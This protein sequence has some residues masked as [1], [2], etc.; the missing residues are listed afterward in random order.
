MYHAKDPNGILTD[1]HCTAY[2]DYHAGVP[3]QILHGASAPDCSTGEYTVH[4]VVNDL[5]LVAQ[6]AV[7]SSPAIEYDY[8]GLGR[9]KEVRVPGDLPIQVTYPTTNGF[10]SQRRVQQ[11][12]FWR[13]ESYDGFGLKTETRSSAGELVERHYDALG[14]KVFASLA[15]FTA[16]DLQGEQFSYDPLGRLRTVTHPGGS[17]LAYAYG[18]TANTLTITDE[19]HRD[20]VQTFRAFAAPEP[21]RLV[22]VQLP[23]EAAPA[24]DTY[25]YTVGGLLTGIQYAGR[26]RSLDY[27]FAKSVVRQSSPESGSVYFGYDP[28]GNLR[29]RDRRSS[30]TCSDANFDDARADARFI[31]DGAGRVRQVLHAS[32]AVPDVTFTFDD[33]NN[34]ASMSDGVGTHV[35]TYTGAGRLQSDMSTVAGVAYSIGYGY[36]AHG[37]LAT[38]T[39]P[40]GRQLTY[41]RDAGN[42]VT[43]IREGAYAYLGGVGYHA[44]GQASTFTYGNGL[45]TTQTQDPRQ[46]PSRLRAAGVFDVRYG[47]DDAGNVTGL[48]DGIEP[49]NTS[50]FG[51]DEKDRLTSASG[52]WG[53]TTYTYNTAG[54]RLTETVDGQTTTYGYDSAGRLASLGG[55]KSTTFVHDAFGNVVQRLDPFQNRYVYD[56]DSDGHLADVKRA[57]GADPAQ[58]LAIFH[59]DGQ[60]RRAIEER[61]GTGCGNRVLHYDRDGNRIAESSESGWILKEMVVHGGQTLAEIDTRPLRSTPAAIDFGSVEPNQ[62]GQQTALLANR[63]AQALTLSAANLPQGFVLG[64]TLP[65]SIPAGG[66]RS[67]AVQFKPASAGVFGGDLTA[68]LAGF[69]LRVPLAGVGGGAR[70]SLDA[71]VQD[72]GTVWYGAPLTRPFRVTNTGTGPLTIQGWDLGGREDLFSVEPAG[73]LT[74]QPGELQDFTLTLKPRKSCGGRIHATVALL[75]NSLNLPN[76]DRFDISATVR[77]LMI[78]QTQFDFA[79]VAAGASSTID[80]PVVNVS[81]ELM[82]LDFTLSGAPQFELAGL[83]TADLAPGDTV[84]VPIT[85]RPTAA[86]WSPF[87][88]HAALRIRFPGCTAACGDDD[89]PLDVH[90]TGM[91]PQEVIVEGPTAAILQAQFLQLV[92]G[93][94]Q[95]L[96]ATK[97]SDPI[98]GG[99][100]L[101]Y[102]TR[103]PQGTWS[104]P[105]APTTA[106]VNGRLA[107][108]VAPDGRA[109]LRTNRPG[110]GLTQFLMQRAPGGAFGAEC[111]VAG[112]WGT[113]PLVYD[114]AGN[115]WVL[116]KTG[117]TPGTY[118]V[119]F[120]P[121]FSP[122]GT[123][124]AGQTPPISFT[125]DVYWSVRGG[126]CQGAGRPVAPGRVERHQDLPRDLRSGAVHDADRVLRAVRPPGRLPGAGRRPAGHLSSCLL[127]E[128]GRPLERSVVTAVSARGAAVPDAPLGRRVEPA[129]TSC[130]N[131]QVM[132]R[133]TCIRG[134]S[135]T[136]RA[137]CTSVP[138]TVTRGGPVRRATRIPSGARTR[139]G[140]RPRSCQACRRYPGS[141][142][143][144]ARATE[145]PRPG[146]PSRRLVGRARSSATARCWLPKAGPGRPRL[147][148]GR[149][150]F[151]T[152]S[153]RAV[154]SRSAPGTR[155]WSSASWRRTCRATPASSRLRCVIP[156]GS[157]PAP[158]SWPT[159][160]PPR[161][162]PPP[163][164]A[165]P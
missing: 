51:L 121:I 162:C 42:R 124:L 57:A 6:Y 102:V 36:D 88:D 21:A 50:V 55:A 140:A 79:P 146:S 8:D 118:Q 37:N 106:A 69:E 116:R 135:W 63:S 65:I 101:S 137:T 99:Y 128:A 93:S 95:V 12:T 53:A 151:R 161:S 40:S 27:D 58:T 148:T 156:R 132:C 112:T 113:D 138:W 92:P 41:D 30:T 11:G 10:T 160:R 154:S 91:L 97:R 122:N 54:D 70:A 147:S 56:F 75:S 144:P 103:L 33:R 78:P 18:T 87:G 43:A 48:T 66:S 155:A 19:M 45:V 32:A 98:N 44:N 20:T 85:Y 142:T 82:S 39:Y 35:Y 133:C 149:A 73:P 7:G 111:P 109:T 127:R 28:A 159:W 38:M 4:Q 100:D 14:R 130:A 76:F 59:Y 1:G 94:T 86:P 165:G 126:A 115:T 2:S 83:A 89:H 77:T 61:P 46:R 34:L 22:R 129:C 13:V 81:D 150:R 152:P 64:T 71:F 17:T 139:V 15:S 62:T 104:A 134:S 74:L 60:G 108:Q 47:Y 145:L 67:V 90:L 49:G 29:C 110:Q 24:S 68:C 143:W 158:T 114:A 131:L 72:F 31:V 52:P 141:S 84:M 163:R 3:Q 136:R 26:Q 123:C 9:P 164:E 25:T 5:G 125:D 120:G 107:F 16:D 105:I 96:Y 117:A 23:G 157:L 80:V 153:R 119:D